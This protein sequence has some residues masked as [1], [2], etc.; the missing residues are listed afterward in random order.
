MDRGLRTKPETNMRQLLQSHSA[1][2]LQT[3]PAL[4]AGVR[5]TELL[6]TLAWLSWTFLEAP[7]P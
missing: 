1:L 7:L 2:G 3:L 4:T 5:G 6:S